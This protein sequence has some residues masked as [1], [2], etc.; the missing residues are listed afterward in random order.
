MPF[1]R[2]K[3]S[4]LIPSVTLDEICF[5]RGLFDTDGCVYRKHGPYMQIQFKSASHS[6]LAYVKASLLK[7]GF[8]PTAITRDDTKFRFF[9]SR[10]N[11]V[12]RFFHVIQPRNAKHLKRF[13][14]ASG[15]QS[16]RSYAYH[17]ESQT[18]S[19]E[20]TKAY[21]NSLATSNSVGQ[22]SEPFALGAVV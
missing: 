1:G 18:D 8:Q 22:P 10:Q 7:L 16:F 4:R 6:L 21:R 5:V 20:P 14:F 11:E 9:L 17:S 19:T 2:K 3:L 12:D 13:Q 15:G